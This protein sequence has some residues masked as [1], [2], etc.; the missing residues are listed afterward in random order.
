MGCYV[1]DGKSVQCPRSIGLL[2]LIVTCLS[3]SAMFMLWSHWM[4]CQ[5]LPAQFTHDNLPILDHD[6]ARAPFIWFQFVGLLFYVG[7]V[8]MM[9]SFLVLGYLGRKPIRFADEDARV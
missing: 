2:A 6:C 3:G 5:L 7:L 8:A 9:L 1:D 4:L